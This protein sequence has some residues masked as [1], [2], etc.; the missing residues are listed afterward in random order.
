MRGSELSALVAEPKLEDFLGGISYSDHHHH[1]QKA[2]TGNMVVPAGSGNGGDTSYSNS[3]GSSVGYLYHPS[4][5]SLQFADSVMVASSASNGSGIGVM[6]NATT[7]NS[8]GSG[9]GL[10]MIK[11][12]L[13]SQPAPAQQRV[14]MAAEGAQAAAQGLSL[15]MNMAAGMPQLLGGERGVLEG[16]STSAQEGMAARKEDAGASSA[17]SGAM[18]S[19]GADSTGGSGGAVVELPAARKS[20]DTFGQRTSIYR[21]VTRYVVHCNHIYT[22]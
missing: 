15:S 11:S 18:V 17:G 10:S 20:A 22:T 7:N 4:S 5:A 12:W 14:E 13:R 8:N 21:G 19:T 6:E 2:A 3:G 16:V 1:Q 9:I